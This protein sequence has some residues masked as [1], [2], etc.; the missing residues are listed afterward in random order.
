MQDGG[1]QMP[2]STTDIVQHRENE[3]GRI[4]GYGIRLPNGRWAPQC[5]VVVFDGWGTGSIVKVSMPSADFENQD[6]AAVAAVD[7]AVDWFEKNVS[8][9]D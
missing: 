7:A 2:N 3:K 8:K 5:K 4:E 1:Y 6:E 9:Y